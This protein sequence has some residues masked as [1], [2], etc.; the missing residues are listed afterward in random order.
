M[1]YKEIIKSWAWRIKKSGCK[2]KDFCEG[3]GFDQSY[4]SGWINGK[5]IPSLENFQKVENALR[6]LGV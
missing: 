1:D 5:R 3:L 6:D 4:M 2:R